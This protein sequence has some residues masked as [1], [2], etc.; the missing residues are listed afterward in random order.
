[1]FYYEKPLNNDI[2]SRGPVLYKH[3]DQNWFWNQL[4][5][6]GEKELIS[7]T[8]A[9]VHSAKN[10]G[11]LRNQ[12]HF[13]CESDMP[14]PKPTLKNI[15]R[16]DGDWD[17]LVREVGEYLQHHIAPHDLKGVSLFEDSH[18]NNWG[19]INAVITHTAGSDPPI[20]QDQGYEIE[21]MFVPDK[22][23]WKNLFRDA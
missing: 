21:Q 11:E 13:Y 22:F 20:L 3:Y 10:V 6:E 8:I 9:L 14:F 1:M 2:N 4:I 23:E 17:E 19:Y 12:Y 5:A 7:G 15:K 16:T 18:P